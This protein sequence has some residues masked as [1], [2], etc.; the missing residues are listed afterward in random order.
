MKITHLFT[1]A[2][3][4]QCLNPSFAENIAEEDHWVM[5]GRR[6]GVAVL[7][8]T[9]KEATEKVGNDC[10]YTLPNGF[11]AEYSEWKEPDKVSTL[12]TFCDRAGRLVQISAETWELP[13]KVVSQQ[14]QHLLTF[15]R[16][17]TT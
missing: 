8:M 1:F 4:I 6:V 10:E 16:N 15:K 7:G 14:S 12:R 13:P 17:T 2:W 9:K 5:P 3:L 11:K